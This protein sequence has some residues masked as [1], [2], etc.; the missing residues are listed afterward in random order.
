M[1]SN[2]AETST[3]KCRTSTWPPWHTTEPARCRRISKLI[4]SV[5]RR[6][7]RTITKCKAIKKGCLQHP[8]NKPCRTPTT[9]QRQ[10]S[11]S[12]QLPKKSTEKSNRTKLK[13]T[14]SS[15]K[16]NRWITNTCGSRNKVKSMHPRT[17][18]PAANSILRSNPPSKT[19]TSAR[20]W[21][22][23]AILRRSSSLSSRNET[24]RSSAW[25]N[26]WVMSYRSRTSSTSSI[27]N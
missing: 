26:M 18:E 10:S 1:T 5:N 4:W 9:S 8:L 12:H 7:L 16:A 13:W 25:S 20:N 14:R 19:C 3:R 27:N 23:E 24:I 2:S 11:S 21:I 15:K 6:S 17:T 22:K